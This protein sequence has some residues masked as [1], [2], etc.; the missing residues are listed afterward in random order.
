MKTQQDHSVRVVALVNLVAMCRHVSGIAHRFSVGKV[1]RSRVWVTYNNPDKYGNERPMAMVFPCYPTGWRGDESN[2]RVI[3]DGLRVVHD[4]WEA[5][6]WLAFQ[7]LLDCPTVWRKSGTEI[8]EPKE[9]G[10][11]SWKE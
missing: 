5:E 10:D 6:G 7:P 4:S 1:T 11:R 8:W 2:P 3:L 9:K